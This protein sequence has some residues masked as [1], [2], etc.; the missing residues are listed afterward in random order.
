MILMPDP[1][2]LLVYE[3]FTGGGFPPGELPAGLAAEATGMLWALLADFRH[4]SQVRTITAL[5]P[6]FETCIPGLDRTT[7]PADE[8]VSVSPDSHPSL[9]LSLVNRC[10][11]AIIIAPETNGILAKLSARV[12]SAGVPLAGSSPS[13]TLL[14][15]DKETCNRIF[16]KATLPVP[17]TYSIEF[18]SAEATIKE[19]DF[20]VVAKP[21]DGIGSEGVC[22]VA[23]PDD[24]PEVLARIRSVTTH[25]RILLQTYQD[26]IHAS[27]SLMIAGNRCLPLSLNR[28]LIRPGKPFV[29]LGSEVP[30]EHERKREAMEL[31]CL[32]AKQIPG[33]RGYAGVD[34]V[35]KKDSIQLIE[36]NP[37]LT[38]SYIGLRQV[39]RTNPARLIYEA[40]THAILPERFSTQGQ[41][42][43]LKDDPGTW[44]LKIGH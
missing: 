39:A 22:L 35:I 28:Q 21:L 4:W 32:A 18:D 20:P 15:G 24:I 44:G 12:E 19:F 23:G 1:S 30:F 26:G 17:E 3:Y 6:R 29:Y 40:C 33:L 8:V 41:V 25:G 16:S 36:I 7:L 31:A 14:A 38:T 37:R 10:D 43:V 9:F 42:T 13:A 2:N 34:I 5:D 27:V 11:A